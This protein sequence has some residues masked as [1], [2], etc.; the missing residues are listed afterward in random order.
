VIRLV[1]FDLDGTLVDSHR[2]IAEAT[3]AVIADLG[4]TPL[5]WRRGWIGI[6]S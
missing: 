2:D 5:I 1:A 4:G 3:N 6:H